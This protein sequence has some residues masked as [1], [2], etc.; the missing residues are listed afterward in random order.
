MGGPIALLEDGDP[1]VID[2]ENKRISVAVDDAAPRKERP[3]HLHPV[4]IVFDDDVSAPAGIQ[5]LGHLPSRPSGA[6]DDDVAL[7]LVD[8]LPLTPH[9]QRSP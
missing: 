7:H 2:A 6:A 8:L 1:I 3:E 4:G 5:L 9:A